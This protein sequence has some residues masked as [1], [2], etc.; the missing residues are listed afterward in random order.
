M[1]PTNPR[2]DGVAAPKADTTSP[3]PPPKPA[4]PSIE[5]ILNTGDKKGK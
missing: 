3:N 1:V 2:P 5:L 4:P